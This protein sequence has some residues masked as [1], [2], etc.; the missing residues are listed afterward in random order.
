MRRKENKEEKSKEI[1]IE[2]KNKID[3]KSINYFYT[4]LQTH[5]IY[6]SSSM[7]RLNN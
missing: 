1:N 4:V 3:L 2:G 5:F 7:S 6:F